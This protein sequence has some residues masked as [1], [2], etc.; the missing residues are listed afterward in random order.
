VAGILAL[1][2]FALAVLFHGFGFSPDAW[3]DWEGM[4]LLGLFFLALAPFASGLPVVVRRRA[5]GE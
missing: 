2:A 4:A 3:L 1:I 5:P